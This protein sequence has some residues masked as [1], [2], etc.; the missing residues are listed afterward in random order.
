MTQIITTVHS[1]ISSRTVVA[2]ESSAG[3]CL[4][5][6]LAEFHRCADWPV[7]FGLTGS[8]LVQ[9]IL[10]SKPCP[11][12]WLWAHFLYKTVNFLPV[13]YRIER[14][15]LYRYWALYK[16]NSFIS[17]ANFRWEVVADCFVVT[18]TRILLSFFITCSPPRRMP[19]GPFVGDWGSSVCLLGSRC[20]FEYTWG[21]CRH[22]QLLRRQVSAGKQRSRVTSTKRQ[23]SAIRGIH[24]KFP[25]DLV[26]GSLSGHFQLSLPDSAR[27]STL[28]VYRGT[29]PRRFL[30]S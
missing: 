24:R 5:V 11:D 4:Q 17:E 13:F 1:P 22:A 15:R 2:I 3:N 7:P 19:L 25:R 23:V 29:I 21:L 9:T 30:Y 28:A 12:F 14:Y 10:P 20:H 16:K 6:D 8:Y 27:N 26:S 18:C